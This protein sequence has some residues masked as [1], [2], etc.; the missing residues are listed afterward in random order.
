MDTS[1]DAL[2]CFLLYA[3]IEIYIVEKIF[4]I[5]RIRSIANKYN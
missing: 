4:G 3:K 2:K 5:T 1:K